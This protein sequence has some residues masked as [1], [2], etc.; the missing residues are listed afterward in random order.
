MATKKKRLTLLVCRTNGH[1]ETEYLPS[2][3]NEAITAFYQAAGQ[4]DLV[5]AALYGTDG[6]MVNNI[7]RSGQIKPKTEARS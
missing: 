3:G 2:K 7:Y 6:H 5:F 1:A 4:T